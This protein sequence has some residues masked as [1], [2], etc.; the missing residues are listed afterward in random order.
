MELKRSNLV[1]PTSGYELDREE[2]SYIEG[3]WLVQTIEWTINIALFALNAG[4]NTARIFGKKAI[5]NFV[6]KHL[7]TWV[8]KALLIM[9][10]GNLAGLAVKGINMLLSFGA[11]Q[12]MRLLS[13][14]GLVATAFDLMDGSWDGKIFGQ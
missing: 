14:G 6:S 10:L 4:I 9:S 1:L 8:S 3:G 2:M 13:V 12:I 7:G 11:D 5:Y